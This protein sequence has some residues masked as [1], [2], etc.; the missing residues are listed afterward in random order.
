[1]RK[2]T[3]LSTIVLFGF[4]CTTS[5]TTKDEPSVPTPDAGTVTPATAKCPTTTTGPTVHEGD[6]AA[7]ETW[8]AEASPHIVKGDVNVRDGKKLVISPCAVVQLE[9][10]ANLNVAFPLTPNQGTLIAEGTAD[11]P[12]RFE[13]KEGARWGRV[14]IHAPGTARFAYVTFENGGGGDGWGMETVT[15]S[16]DNELPRKG[17]L[18]VDHVTVKSSRGAGIR[19]EN[20]GAFAPG[21]KDLVITG[22]G[23]ATNNDLHPYPLDVGESAIDTIPTGTYTGN[24]KDEIFFSPE[25]AS[26]GGGF[27]EDTTMRDRGVPYHVS[28]PG[29]RIDL[30]IGNGG[31]RPAT[32]TIEAGVK[33]LFE[34]GATLN[35][36]SDTT[37]TSAIRAL[38]T[39]EKPVVFT[40]A[41]ATPAP[42]DWRGFYFNGPVGPKNALEHVRIEYTGA[43]C[44]CSMLTCSG[45]TEFEAAIIFSQEPTTM[46]M[47]DSVIAHSSGN[48]V[49]QGYDGLGYDWKTGN[50][51]DDVAGCFVTLPRNPSTDC[52]DPAPPC[53]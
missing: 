11:A 24:K 22:S 12:I 14:Y 9:A 44:A 13:G 41:S 20:A 27:Q 19:M 25:N 35:V 53:R 48:G 50:T 8:T 43:D 36:E 40:S 2:L 16:G 34:K 49:V 47:K 7:D 28:R 15:A 38:G 42:G 52:P 39:A 1:M 37:G 6:I 33:L 5:S 30:Q 23:V 10:D 46:F 4:A 26:N 3:F 32:L 31:N 29:D 45:V 18:F 51:F 21:S 17:I